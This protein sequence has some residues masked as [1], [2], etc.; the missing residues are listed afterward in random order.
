MKNPNLIHKHILI[1]L[2]GL[3][4]LMGLFPSWTCGAQTNVPPSP[5]KQQTQEST[6][7]QANR[8]AANQ[9]LDMREG[10]PDYKAFWNFAKSAPQGVPLEEQVRWAVNKVNKGKARRPGMVAVDRGGKTTYTGS[11]GG[12]E[13]RTPHQAE[14]SFNR[15]EGTGHYVPPGGEAARK[16]IRADAEKMAA[17]QGLDM[18]P[19]SADYR[20]FYT[21]VD[22]L[23]NTPN[24]EYLNK[25]FGEQ[26]KWAVN[27]VKAGRLGAPPV[28]PATETPLERINQ[29]FGIK[30]PAGAPAPN[31]EDQ[32]DSIAREFF[33]KHGIVVPQSQPP[34]ATAEVKHKVL[35]KGIIGGVLGGILG[36]CLWVWGKIK[37]K[38]GVK[39]VQKIG[40]AVTVE[41]LSLENE[42]KDYPKDRAM[43]NLNL[44]QKRILLVGVGII[45]LM[46]LIPPWSATTQ[47]IHFSGYPHKAIAS[48][49]AESAAGYHFIFFPPRKSDFSGDSSNQTDSSIDYRLDFGRLFIQW[50]FVSLS[51]A[52]LMFYFKE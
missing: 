15:K 26:V 16:K 1:V 30:L 35:E 47:T 25:P 3:I 22:E 36:L 37:K 31:P 32:I 11:E 19:G 40:Q 51:T 10:S 7:A 49:A 42:T 43:K 41:G 4:V 5:T 38:P 8:L 20:L 45:I 29:Q 17:G 12:P 21:F 13:Y 24:H 46:G 48:H 33:A 44:M 18:T 6:R 34:A 39:D 23:A 52:A 27:K 9:G 2:F 50:F 28:A 14:Q